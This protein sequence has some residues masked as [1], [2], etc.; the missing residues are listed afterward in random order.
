[1]ELSKDQKKA[2]AHRRGHL[3]IIACPGSGKT[4]VVSRR[5]A[6]LV[7]DGARPSSVVAFT[8]TEKAA[9]ELK[10]RIR[11]HLEAQCP[12]KSD[13]GDMFVGTIDAFCLHEIKQLRPAYRQ[14]EVLD[15]ARRMAFIDRW[16]WE[17]GLEKLRRGRAGKWETMK[18]F[19]DSMD[20]M[21]GESISAD[22]LPDREFAECHGRYLGKLKDERF[23][24]F[25]SIIRTLLGEL[26]V[27]SIALDRLNGDI[28]HVVLD[29]YQDVNGLQERLLERLSR[30]SES[31]CVV[32]DDDQNIFQWRGSNVRHIIDFPKKYRRYGVTTVKLETNYRAT[33]GLIGAA[34]RLI[35]N[36]GTRVRKKIR[37][38]QEKVGSGDGDIVHHHFETDEEEFDYMRRCIAGLLGA[39]FSG[40]S[41]ERFALSHG[42]MAVIVKTN[43][44]AARIVKYLERHE[45]PCTADSGDSVFERPLVRLAMDCLF[46]AFDCPGYGSDEV[47]DLDALAR[48]YRSA[49]RRGNAARFRKGMRSV[50]GMASEIAS[51]DGDWLPNLGL[52]EFYQRVLVAMGA[53]GDALDDAAMYS[54]AVLSTAISDYEYVYRSLRARQV[55]GLKWFLNQ[56]A[57]SVYSDPRREDPARLDAVRVLTIWKAKGLEF[58][59]V[60]VPSFDERRRQSPRRYF[61]DD[62]L[63][64]RKRYDGGVEDDRRAYYTA[65]TRSQKYLFLTGAR[66]KSIT[67]RYPPSRKNY[68][69]HPF[70]KEMGDGAFAGPAVPQARKSGLAPRPGR[71]GT[72]P[73]SYSSLSIYGRCPYDYKVRHVFGFNAGVP[74]AFGY[75]TNIHNILNRIHSEYVQKGSAPTDAEIGGMFDDMFHLRFAPGGMGDEMKKKGAR[76]VR[77]YVDLH[78]DDF[79]R[80][81]D[82]ERRFEF[83][84]G[85]ALIT[86]SIDLLKR[87]DGRGEVTDVE[88]IDF[89]TESEKG[90]GRYKLDHKEQARFYAHA[91]KNSLGYRPSRAVVHHL[92]GNRRDVVDIGDA[93]LEATR[94]GISEKVDRIIGGDFAAAPGDAKCGGCDFRALC[95]HKGFDVGVGFEPARSS[96]KSWKSAA[97]GGQAG[98]LAASPYVLERARRLAADPR[99]AR[100]ADGTYT[101][102]SSSPGAAYRVTISA[103]RC[104]GF[105]KHLSLNP[106]TA[107]TCSHVE[108]VKI[109]ER[110]RLARRSR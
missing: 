21:A 51:K 16:Y 81:L 65:V 33:D 103:C 102:P 88:I 106:G 80:I 11:G 97:G 44:D 94:E 9:G 13:F 82:T 87:T 36:N 60:F 68:R 31:V 71:G 57:G 61:V 104:L 29:E 79:G 8:F 89:K 40:G 20:R 39:D 18:V 85:D 42:D 26:D 63:Y 58:P 54:L 27:D 28:K 99:T 35:S 43:E 14:F 56:A 47:P 45:V 93:A 76:L 64:D 22:D 53:E 72:F 98:G 4:E 34:S 3:R 7:R 100:N 12:E 30:G 101:V 92:D 70:I 83:V 75:G 77:N 67:V 24:D 17:L 23:F 46:Y 6:G 41:G 48:G 15:S 84:L 69:P 52:Q 95:R 91:V 90:D 78:K 38:D 1:M 5:V 105:K 10:R 107:P 59:A 19:C 62:S 49:V 25:V 66:R 50:R 86:G 55:A 73:T 96:K 74:S 32:G 110:R 37:V 108:A 109:L 2:V